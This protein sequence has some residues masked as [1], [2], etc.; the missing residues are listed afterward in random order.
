MLCSYP[1]IMTL[2]TPSD[3]T[4]EKLK[5]AIKLSFSFSIKPK[6]IPHLSH[7]LQPALSSLQ[8]V[9]SS[10]LLDPNKVVCFRTYE[11]KKS[12]RSLVHNALE[13]KIRY[14]NIKLLVYYIQFRK[15]NP[16]NLE[17]G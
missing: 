17:F 12:Q 2:Y 6:D 11:F 13:D 7:I 5:P 14:L 16:N 15:V 8:I 1:T 10:F 9:I 3:A 4:S